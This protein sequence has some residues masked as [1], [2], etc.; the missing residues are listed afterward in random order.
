VFPGNLYS[1]GFL[2][3]RKPLKGEIKIMQKTNQERAGMSNDLF[4][5]VR[6]G[7]TGEN[8]SIFWDSLSP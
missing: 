2:D 8:F 7:M 3:P 5:P 6:D 4:C 1:S